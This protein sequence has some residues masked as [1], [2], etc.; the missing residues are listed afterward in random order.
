MKQKSPKKIM[1]Y[2]QKK[3]LLLVTN[4]LFQKGTYPQFGQGHFEKDLFTEETNLSRDLIL[5][6]LGLTFEIQ[7]ISCTLILEF[8]MILC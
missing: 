2:R 4:L 3:N 8:H 5:D 6:E 1:K 7:S